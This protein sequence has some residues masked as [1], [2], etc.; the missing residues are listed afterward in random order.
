MELDQRLT[1]TVAKNAILVDGQRVLDLDNGRI[2]LNEKRG[3]NVGGNNFLAV[4]LHE[5]M[6]KRREAEEA[7][8]ASA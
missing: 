6:K 1:V 8:A 3:G 7:V 2:Q 5:V 4:Q